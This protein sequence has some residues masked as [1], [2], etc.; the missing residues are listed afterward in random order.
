IRPMASHACQSAGAIALS[1]NRFSSIQVI[2]C[3]RHT[4]IQPSST[5]L[6][7]AANINDTSDSTQVFKK[8]HESYQLFQGEK[9]IEKL[10]QTQGYLAAWHNLY[11]KMDSAVH[12]IQ[13]VI[14]FYEDTRQMDI[15]AK[16]YLQLSEYLSSRADFAEAM[17]AVFKALDIYQDMDNQ[18]GISL[19]YTGLCDLLYSQ[20]KFEEGNVYCDMAIA[21]QTKLDLP[22]DLAITYRRKSAN[23]LFIEGEK[24]HA[25]RV[26]NQ[27]IAIYDE[28]GE[29]GLL[30][31]ACINWRGNILKYLDRFDEALD[32]YHSNLEKSEEMGLTR[33]SLVSLAN[34]GHVFTMQE[35][36]EQAIPYTL[37]AIEIMNK[38]GNTKNL[39]E[40][41]M[42]VANSYEKLGRFEE[43][44]KYNKLHAEAYADFLRS[45]T[46]R[47]ESELLVK[48]ETE[49]KQETI[50]R[51]EAQIAQQRKVQILYISIAGILVMSLFGILKTLHSIR[52]K[53]KALQA[54]NLQLDAKNRQNELLMK[55]I[56]HR[57][58]NN[59]ELV[60]SLIALQCAQM[61]DSASKDAMVESQ[62]RVQSMGIIHQKLYQGENLGGI[63]MKEYFI[64]LSEGILDAFDAENKVKIECAMENL[65]LDIDTAVPIGLIVNELLT[66]S[67][68]YAFPEN[69]KGMVKI[70]LSQPDPGLLTLTVSDNGVGKINGQQAR[71]TGFG[72]QLIHLLTRQLNG[73]MTET[74]ES[75]TSTR[76]RFNISKAA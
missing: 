18:R 47:L 65:E 58:K 69:G 43:A 56:H 22:E 23:L 45:S 12:Y 55:E 1:G 76:F 71:G 9:N 59:L 68:K 15:L 37:K 48:Y 61:E 19:C 66:N 11:G 30:Y 14:P 31:M 74:T 70:S 72:S 73:E 51:Q 39:W 46:E 20:Y 40:N 25:L 62:N 50:S 75:G 53:R 7:I 13:L 64:N 21:I 24:E 26:I 28:M 42:H 33:Y 57:V 60:K 6:W 63:E 38:T 10:A 44:L 36:Y 16:T 2:R 41:Y 67:L 27:A 5:L 34:I 35:K 4:H 8:L 54:L 49:K 3:N 52:K 17:D 32:D 29:T